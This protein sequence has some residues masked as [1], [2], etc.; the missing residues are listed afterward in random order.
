MIYTDLRDLL[1]RRLQD[2][3]NDE[4]TT[5]F[6]DGLLGVGM[7]KLQ[8]YIHDIKVDAFVK[9]V[10]ISL[11][12]ST[13]LYLKSLGEANTLRS[14]EAEVLQASSGL[15][16]PV[17]ISNFYK[18]RARYSDAG[19]IAAA[20]GLEVADLGNQWYVQPT[21]SA[22]GTLRI[23]VVPNIGNQTNWDAIA[24]PSIPLALHTL[25]VDFAV[26]ECLGE[27]SDKAAVEE[28]RARIADGL[29]LVPL[30]YGR[31][32]KQVDSLQVSPFSS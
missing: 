27:T 19:G 2:V 5:A 11:V 16:K 21:P 15:Y 3:A 17:T 23:W 29:T 6:L 18:M 31:S 28:A 32:M 8:A 1:E 20:D 7:G 26:I 25:P 22:A 24:E 14:I 13:D 30:L 12:A 9:R 10:S 4:F